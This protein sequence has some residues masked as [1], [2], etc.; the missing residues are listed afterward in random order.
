MLFE[1]QKG[2]LQRRKRFAEELGL[3]HEKEKKMSLPAPALLRLLR[4]GEVFSKRNLLLIA[5]PN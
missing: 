1:A 4:A 5:K 3:F 2:W